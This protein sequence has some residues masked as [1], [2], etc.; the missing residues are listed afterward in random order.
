MQGANLREIM[1]NQSYVT[2]SVPSL[3]DFRTQVFHTPNIH[4]GLY[5]HLYH[6]EYP[7]PVTLT[8]QC[9]PKCNY[10]SM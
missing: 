5:L 9:F 3:T 10:S 7:S 4:R 6:P 1:R 2:P 8:T